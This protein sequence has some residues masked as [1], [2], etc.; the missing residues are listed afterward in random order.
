MKKYLI[1]LLLILSTISF[2]ITKREIPKEDRQRI[3]EYTLDNT[4]SGTER[5]DFKK[6]QEDAYWD[7][8]KQLD[9]SGITES[10]KSAVRKRL[11]AMYGAN[12]TK[13]TKEVKEQVKY[14][15]V[16]S[17]AAKEKKDMEVRNI[18]SKEELTTIIKEAEVTV[19][20]KMMK[21]YKS[22]AERLYPNNY[23]EQKRYIESSINT[24]KMFK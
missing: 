14:Y 12:Y 8:E 19:P 21:H 15:T 20:E 5:T 11:N 24:Y 22:E 17:R 3:M 6:W 7:V 2:S 13:Q 16:V 9:E 4:D 1:G 18:E 10:E 23:Y